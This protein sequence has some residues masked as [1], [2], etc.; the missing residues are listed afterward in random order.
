VEEADP[1]IYGMAVDPAIAGQLTAMMVLVTS[2]GGTGER[3]AIPGV[4]VAAKTGTAENAAEGEDHAVFT[5][6]APADDPQV[7]VGVVV[8]NGGFGGRVAAPIAKAI[9]QAVL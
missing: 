2:P 3:A 1:A 9:M 7:A 6:F 4:K 5:A 8:E